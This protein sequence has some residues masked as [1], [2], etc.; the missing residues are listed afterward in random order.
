MFPEL[1]FCQVVNFPQVFETT[2][3]IFHESVFV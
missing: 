1:L 3:N 2:V